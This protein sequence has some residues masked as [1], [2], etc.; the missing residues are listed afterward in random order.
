MHSEFQFSNKEITVAIKKVNELLFFKQDSNWQ[1]LLSHLLLGSIT[2][3]KTCVRSHINFVI[4]QC[5]EMLLTISP[6]NRNKK[7]VKTL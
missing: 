4:I 1:L 3:F 7:N 6:C 5:L 2:T